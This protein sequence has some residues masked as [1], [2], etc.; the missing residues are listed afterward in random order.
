MGKTDRA[1]EVE[2]IE[3]E[4]RKI[5]PEKKMVYANGDDT[6]LLETQQGLMYTKPCVQYQ[7]WAP[8]ETKPTVES[9]KQIWKYE[10]SEFGQMNFVTG[11]N[12][13]QACEQARY[14]WATHGK[15]GTF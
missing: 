13:K 5:T 3:A 4:E 11:G 6:E 15:T 8:W 10:R 14:K 9:G 12:S 7:N 1:A 2:F